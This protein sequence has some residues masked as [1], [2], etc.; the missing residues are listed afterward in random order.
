MTDS[1]SR[2][3]HEKGAVSKEPPPPNKFWPRLKE[4]GEH[5]SSCG[6]RLSAAGEIFLPIRS[7][8]PSPAVLLIGKRGTIT[9]FSRRFRVR[10]I[11]RLLLRTLRSPASVGIPVRA[12]G[13][14][15]SGGF[16]NRK[17]VK[18]G[19]A[20]APSTGGRP[21]PRASEFEVGKFCWQETFSETDQPACSRAP[22]SGCFFRAG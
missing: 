1:A 10:Q 16:I 14:A 18:L 22:S 5:V 19:R 20:E 2:R 15:Q 3:D 12:R 11:E 8:Y 7:S 13:G 9:D 21:R 17:M 4:T 6:S